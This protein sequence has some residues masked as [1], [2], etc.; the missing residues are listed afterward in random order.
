M[1]G[2]TTIPSVDLTYW[3][4]PVTSVDTLSD[5]RKIPQADNG[6]WTERAVAVVNGSA[7]AFDGSFFWYSWNPN[8]VSADSAPNVIKPTVITGSGRWELI[9][10]NNG[11]V[12][13]ISWKTGAGDPNATGVVADGLGQRYF[14]TAGDFPNGTWYWNGTTWI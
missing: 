1:P 4:Q 13:V 10:W 8:S 12:P 7:S 5:L 2:S 3:Q 6:D 14:Q 9:S 11:G